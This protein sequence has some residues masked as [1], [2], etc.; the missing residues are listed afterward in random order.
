MDFTGQTALAATTATAT[1]VAGGLFGRPLREKH[2]AHH[3]PNVLRLNNGSFGACP[4][5]VL[6]KQRELQDE[7][8]SNPDDFWHS[9]SSRFDETTAVVASC[10]L[11]VPA[12]EVCLVDNLTTGM[13]ALTHSLIATIS[14][15]GSAVLISN[16]TYNAVKLAIKHCCALAE[17]RHGITIDI[18]VVDI[19]FPILTED[20]ENVILACFKKALQAVRSNRVIQFAFIDHITSVPAMKLPLQRI[21]PLLREH[22]VREVLVDAAHAPG[23]L[24]LRDTFLAETGPAVPDYYLANLHK[25]CLAPVS[26]GF[27]W[28]SPSAPS[29]KKLYH[30]IVSHLSGQGFQAECSM[31][32]TKDYSAMLAVPTALEFIDTHLGG[33]P[34]L[35]ERNTTL[36]YAAALML[37]D[38]W[39]TRE[40]LSPRGLCS[41]LA[42]VGCPAALGDTLEDGERLRLALRAWKPASTPA[43]TPTL[44]PAPAGSESSRTLLYGD[45]SIPLPEHVT[46]GIVIQKLT[47]VKGDRLYLRVSA[48]AYNYIEEYHVL[49]DAVLCIASSSN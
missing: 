12:D 14:E 48:A 30:P 4:E 32:G 8:N 19:P 11:N 22:G 36:C 6:K 28:I 42:M 13:A 7:W 2:F 45:N 38:A 3:A 49:R 18:I 9:L 35:M 1:A 24:E 17:S 10:V 40:F 47:A 23:Q 29:R 33:L 16:H 26:A 5:G 46:G 43:P 15:P 31:L 34:T 37:S 27:L 25:W 21:V 20:Y 39:G 41:G 44:A